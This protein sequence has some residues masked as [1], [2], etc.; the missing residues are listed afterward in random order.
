M[1]LEKNQKINLKITS[2]GSSGEGIGKHNGITIFVEGALPGEEI[3]ASV[4]KTKKNYAFAKLIKLV[5]SSPDRVSPVCP[6]FGRCGGC[7]IMHLKYSEQL[8]VKRQKV[9]DALERIGKLKNI[10]VEDCVPSPEHLNYRNKVQLPVKTIDDIFTIGFFKKKS[11]Q[12]IPVEQCHIHCSIGEQVLATVKSVILEERP[13]IQSEIKHIIIK[14]S[15]KE[16]KVLVILVRSGKLKKSF[17]LLGQLLMDK[18]IEIAGVV[19]NI[20]SSSRGKAVTGDRW[21]TLSGNPFIY[22]ELCDVKFK[23]SPASFFQVN[24]HQAEQLYEKVIQ[25]AS[26]DKSKKILD[27]Y[28]GIG[29]LSLIA[30]KHA[31]QV[32]GIEYIPQAIDDARANAK[33][34]QIDNCEFICGKTED[35]IE[36]YCNVDIVFVNPPRQGCD[37]KV[38]SALGRLNNTQIVYISC[39]PAT[40]ARDL[41]H[42]VESGYSIR[43]VAPFDMFPQT[44]H[45]ETIVL[46]EKQKKNRN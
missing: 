19:E 17:S 30:A 13:D 38:I 22:E 41:A 25:I 11:H 7:Q 46:L 16:G 29:T 27:T 42:L 40:L 34:N 2:I 31:K 23:I 32:L 35:Y 15:I 24:T 12:V 5:S 28:C 9:I 14:S 21:N 36:K 37:R 45:V 3:I 18:C 39:D 43:T 44:M 6:V 10:Y 1:I 33:L 26:I 8:K 4:I 20:N